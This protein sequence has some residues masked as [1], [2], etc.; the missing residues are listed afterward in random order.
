MVE[1]CDTMLISEKEA[2]AML[3]N[4]LLGTAKCHLQAKKQQEKSSVYG[5]QCWLTAVQCLLETFATNKAIQAAVAEFQQMK[6]N[7]KE[8]EAEFYD[9]FLELHTRAGSFQKESSLITSF[10]EA[11]DPR[12][13]PTLRGYRNNHPNTDMTIILREAKTVGEAVRAITARPN[14]DPRFLL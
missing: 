1:V 10:I 9:L 11:L 13:L 3:A 7:S 2:Y 6:Q 14:R 12:I 4:F 8:S 5:V